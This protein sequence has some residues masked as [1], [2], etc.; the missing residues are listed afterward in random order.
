MTST[1]LLM[2]PIMCLHGVLLVNGRSSGIILRQWLKHREHQNLQD[3]RPLVHLTCWTCANKTDNEACN[4][5]APDVMC[6]ADHSVCKSVHHVNIVT[7]ETESVTK[8]CSA[9]DECSSRDVGCHDTGRDDDVKRCVSCCTESY[10]NE[11]V[12]SDQSSAISLS[13]TSLTSTSS[14]LSLKYSNYIVLA[15]SVVF[16]LYAD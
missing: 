13:V 15:M 11:A 5:W 10:C 1:V 4:D 6:P 8:T 14:N 2:L 3:E 7:M 12:P 16:V 9:P